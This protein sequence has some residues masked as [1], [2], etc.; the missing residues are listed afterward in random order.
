[1]WFISRRR[2]LS[3]LLAAIASLPFIS[4]VHAAQDFPNRSIKIY[5]GF[6][7][8]GSTDAPMRV[9]AEKAA[10]IL[11][12]PIVVENRTGAGGTLAT[13]QLQYATNDGFTLSLETISRYRISFFIDIQLDPN[14]TYIIV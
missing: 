11:G 14:L 7:P 10:D 3:L 6:P 2:I 13:L 8:G 1:M 5:I 4:T 9:L 12:Q